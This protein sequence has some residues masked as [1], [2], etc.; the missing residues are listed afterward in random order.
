MCSK[1][2]KNM[3][4]KM[5]D[6]IRFAWIIFLTHRKLPKPNKIQTFWSSKNCYHYGGYDEMTHKDIQGDMSH[7]KSYAWEIEI[8]KWLKI[9]ITCLFT[10][11]A[12]FFEPFR[13]LWLKKWAMMTQPS[14]W[15]NTWSRFWAILKSRFLM[16][17]TSRE[18]CLLGCL[19]EPSHHTPRTDFQKS[20][21][22]GTLSC[23]KEGW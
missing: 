6:I 14:Q 1:T 15:K 23:W 13:F 4:R 9:S 16:H 21:N 3:L 5:K 20:G 11:M 7:V 12:H 18:T 8:S 22:F 19:F 17:M 2:K 10:E